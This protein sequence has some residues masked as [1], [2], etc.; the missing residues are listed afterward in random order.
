VT[1]RNEAAEIGEPLGGREQAAGQP[2]DGP[3]ANRAQPVSEF[4]ERRE[5]VDRTPPEPA[6]EPHR[7]MRHAGQHVDRA[8]WLGGEHAGHHH[9][10]QQAP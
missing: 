6:D 9:E 4:F 1:G 8:L 2:V 7:P 3:R 5:G 10:A